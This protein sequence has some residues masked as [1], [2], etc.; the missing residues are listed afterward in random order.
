MNSYFYSILFFLI[1]TSVFSQKYYDSND[2]DYYIDFSSK[3]ANLKFQEFEING[4]LEDIL[5]HY[6]NKFTIIKGD[7]I[8][9]LLQQSETRNKYLSYLILKGDYKE[10]RNL[11]KWE[12]SNK[13]LEVL[14]SDYILSGY[15]K[16]HFNFVNENEYSKI[17]R[18]RKIGDYLADID[19]IGNYNIKVLRDN[20]VNYFDL[21]INGTLEINQRGIVIET[22][23]P[24]LTKFSGIY[25]SEL[26][27]NLE[28]IKMGIISGKIENNEESIFSIS[29]DM[30]KKIIILTSLLVKFNNEG[31]KYNTKNTT[32]FIIE[33]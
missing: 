30:K 7:S 14:A 2:L 3:N 13:K 4:P 27:P 25:D 32:T 22:N 9:W 16:D 11:A 17:K 1:T 10:V 33:Q 24:T 5:S 8:H 29:I 19:L 15:F 26:N 6:G 28:F 21:D 20:G 18:N 12:F 31:N 23:L